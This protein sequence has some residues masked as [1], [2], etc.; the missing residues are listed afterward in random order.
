MTDSSAHGAL[1][2]SI[3]R[4]IADLA[5]LAL[6]DDEVRT[7]GRQLVDILAYVELLDE[8]PTEGVEPTSFAGSRI[9]YRPPGLRQVLAPGAHLANA[10]DSADGAFRVPKVIG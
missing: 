5:R 7:L 4:K 8:V 6:D 10:P 3:V 1:D 9:V 2:E